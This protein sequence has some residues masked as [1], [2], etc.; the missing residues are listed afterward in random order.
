M[1]L[2]LLVNGRSHRGRLGVRRPHDGCMLSVISLLLSQPD[3]TDDE[4]VRALAGDFW[5]CGTF[6]KSAAPSVAISV[7]RMRTVSIAVAPECG[8][9]SNPTLA[10]SRLHG[11]NGRPLRKRSNRYPGVSLTW[12]VGA[13]TGRNDTIAYL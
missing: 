13:L 9:A 7:G 1:P 6:A 2:R 11:G 8:R 5:R 10:E 4:I 3:P 12:L